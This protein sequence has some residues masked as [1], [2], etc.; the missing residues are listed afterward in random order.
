M[1]FIK[2]GICSE[3]ARDL[4]RS[5]DWVREWLKIYYKESITGI[6]NRPKSVGPTTIIQRVKV[7]N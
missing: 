6:K 1:G 2:K 4:Y 5:K 7:S 3:V